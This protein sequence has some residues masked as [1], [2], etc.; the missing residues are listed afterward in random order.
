M[1]DDPDA[2]KI[3][4]TSE[5]L[6]NQSV[7]ER[8]A[9][10]ERARQVA[11][12]RDIGTP[13]KGGSTGRAILTLT[14][15]GAV[16]GALAFLLQRVLFSSLGLFEDNVT[17]TNVGFTF[18]LALMIG[19]GV[20]MAD[21][22]GNRT[23][24]KIGS[25]AAIAI[26]AA[27]G[28]GLV[29]GF[30]AHLV[31]TAGTEWIINSATELVFTG[32][33]VTDE[34]FEN[35]VRLR[36]HPVRGLAWL[37]V[38]VA[39]GISAGAASRSW[40]RLGL[41]TAGGAAGGF[42]GGFLFD[43]FNLGEDSADLSEIIAQLVGIVLVGLLIGLATALVEQ[44]GK[45]R[46]I[47][48]IRGGLAGK[49]FILYKSTISLGSSPSAD[50]TLIKDP[51]IAPIAAQISV[52][53]TQCT[54]SAAVAPQ[55]GNPDSAG[56]VLVNGQPVSQQTITD[57]DVVTIAGTELRFRERAQKSKIPGALKQ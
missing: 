2:R 33:L 1:A 51:K 20:S 21:V 36:L 5:D 40:K 22:V 54:I 30:V 24:S 38:G 26:P 18:V 27:I 34:Q 11:L 35:F 9:E 41:A 19:I 57:M 42:L 50:I 25:V 10:M 6:A 46:W 8:L 14:V 3:H 28:A 44:A 32:E 12:V 45:S 56:L 53:G 7:D 16:G 39:A 47:E 23:W 13:T 29:L 15:G 55:Q 31:Y 17:A 37:F 43:F 48:I 4:I 49:Q 52:Q